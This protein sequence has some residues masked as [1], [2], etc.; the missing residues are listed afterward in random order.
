MPPTAWVGSLSPIDRQSSKPSAS[1]DDPHAALADGGEQ[2][3]ALGSSNAKSEMRPL[4]SA[5]PRPV[6]LVVALVVGDQRPAPGGLPRA[7]GAGHAAGAGD[8]LALAQRARVRAGARR[9]LPA[10][11][12]AAA[13]PAGPSS[14]SAC[15]SGVFARRQSAPPSRASTL[16]LGLDRTH[17]WRG[18]R[19]PPRARRTRRSRASCCAS[20]TYPGGQAS[21]KRRPSPAAGEGERGGGE[22]R[23]D[24]QR[25]HRVRGIRCGMT[26]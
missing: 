8:R 14:S 21:A 2:P 15:A 16:A 7:A 3:P 17:A 9:G 26:M 11:G 19:R 1:S 18:R 4:T 23:D 10:A 13:I 6:D 5:R 24:E 25:D 22:Q 12:A 20:V